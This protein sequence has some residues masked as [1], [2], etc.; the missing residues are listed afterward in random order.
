MAP[1]FAVLFWIRH[2]QA[3]PVDRQHVI[4]SGAQH[5]ARLFYTC[6]RRHPCRHAYIRG[7]SWPDRAQPRS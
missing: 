6:A 7:R 1:R 2:P 5:A 3:W 4:V